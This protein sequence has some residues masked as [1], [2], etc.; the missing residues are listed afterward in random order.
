[1]QSKRRRRDPP[2]WVIE[3][4][5]LKTIIVRVRPSISEIVETIFSKQNMEQ[6]WK[7]Y[8]TTPRIVDKTTLQMKTVLQLHNKL[9]IQNNTMDK[10][11]NINENNWTT[12]PNYW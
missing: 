8:R 3:T 1:M 12:P 7:N 5:F 9:H 10:V 4:H 11:Q 6:A 2:I